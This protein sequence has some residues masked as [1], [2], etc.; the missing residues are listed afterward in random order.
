MSCVSHAE[1]PNVS[2]DEKV[3]IENDGEFYTV[4]VN[5]SVSQHTIDTIISRS[6]IE[7]ETYLHYVFII[8]HMYHLFFLLR[9]TLRVYVPIHSEL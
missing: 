8:S 4:T 9:E 7:L 2:Y 3:K 5:F 6:N 1:P